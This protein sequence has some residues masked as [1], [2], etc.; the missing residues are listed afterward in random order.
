[1]QIVIVGLTLFGVVALALLATKKLLP[2]ANTGANNSNTA[3]CFRG[4]LCTMFSSHHCRPTLTRLHRAPARSVPPRTGGSGTGLMLFLAAKCS[5][6]AL[7]VFLPVNL[8]SWCKLHNDARVISPI[9]GKGLTRHQ[10]LAI[11]APS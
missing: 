2:M 7:A 8:L 1:M 6:A 10:D 5:T 4:F 3:E 11:Q 9:C